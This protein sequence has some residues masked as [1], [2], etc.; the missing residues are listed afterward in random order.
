MQSALLQNYFNV[1]SSLP[2]SAITELCLQEKERTN[3]RGEEDDEQLVWVQ[4]NYSSDITSAS[5]SAVLKVS[6]NMDVTIKHL[7]KQNSPKLET[8]KNRVLS[9]GLPL[10]RQIAQLYSHIY[11]RS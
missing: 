6:T 2:T 9:L 7:Y 5:T 4:C 11:S 8:A 3:E 10:R 1:Y